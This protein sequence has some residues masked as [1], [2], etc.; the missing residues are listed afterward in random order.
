VIA[1]D[2]L[3]P[4]KK[5]IRGNT[6]THP[7]SHSIPYCTIVLMFAAQVAYNRSPYLVT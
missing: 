5:E 7:Q 2:T 1:C 3:P 6:I 4:K